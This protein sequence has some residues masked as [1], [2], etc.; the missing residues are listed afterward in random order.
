MIY[1]TLAGVL[2]SILA[3][4]SVSTAQARERKVAD[5]LCGRQ[6]NG[7]PGEGMESLGITVERAAPFCFR[8]CQ[9]VPACQVYSAVAAPLG[10]CSFFSSPVFLPSLL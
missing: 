1:P 5:M 2:A 3:A 6:V 7:I 8:E 4:C 9:R 10:V